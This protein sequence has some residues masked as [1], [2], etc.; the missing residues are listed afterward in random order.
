MK[1]NKI[2]LKAFAVTSLFLLAACSNNSNRD[3]DTLKN[4]GEKDA[5]SHVQ[6]ESLHQNFAHK[7]IIILKD[8]YILEKQN[9]DKLK[10]VINDYLAMKNAFII[11]DIMAIDSAAF[12]MQN[13][14][15]EVDVKTLKREGKEAWVQHASTYNT[16]LTELIH[17]KGIE[18]KRSYLSHLSEIVYCTKK[19]FKLN[20]LKLFAIYCPM[21]FE[22]KGAYWI[23]ES[24]EIRNPYF[25]STMIDCGTIEEKL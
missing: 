3:K 22:G 9:E 14:V 21:A 7:E 12:A 13:H 6:H 19:S 8:P 18:E 2:I 17:I 11:S 16:K 20:E 25:G 4:T 24:E 10:E 5:I 1:A 23:S 15:K